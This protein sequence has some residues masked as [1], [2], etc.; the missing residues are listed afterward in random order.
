MLGT[1]LSAASDECHDVG[2]WSQ[3]LH[4]GHLVEDFL[5]L[6]GRSTVFDTL[7]R[8]QQRPL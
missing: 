4:D 5:F 1:L 7:H 2:M 8:Y 3:L 6:F